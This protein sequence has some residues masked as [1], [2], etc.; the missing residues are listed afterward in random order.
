MRGVSDVP[1]KSL[2]F[3]LHD[4]LML[5]AP[6]GWTA[7]DLKVIESKGALWLSELEAT[8]QGTA[9]A[10]PR[11]PFYVE[12]KDEA[13]HLS[14]ALTELRGRL[15]RPWTPGAVRVER[16]GT[17]FED[18]K[19]L[20]PNGGVVWFTRLSKDELD[21]L[22]VTEALL[23]LV[24][25]TSRAFAALEDQLEQRLGRVQSF[26]FDRSGSTLVLD[27]PE[28]RLTLA[29]QLVGVHLSRD[30]RWVWSW[31]DPEAPR[32]AVERIASSPREYP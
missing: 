20:G 8:G 30:F 27:R 10:Q 14:E 7:V 13:R 9:E 6:R 2:V 1:L 18:W 26:T 31:S 12:P 21:G 16:K 4:S 22:L 29:A 23:D 3:A 24:T 32:A 25:G 19:L 5:L 11:A 15:G 28:G 17:D